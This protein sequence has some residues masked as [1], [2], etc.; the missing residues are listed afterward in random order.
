M[1]NALSTF[2][3]MS[4]FFVLL[5]FITT[6][7]VHG[8]PVKP[9]RGYYGIGAQLR[10]PYGQFDDYDELAETDPDFHLL[11]HPLKRSRYFTQRLGK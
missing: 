4:L 5:I 3:R 1:M 10:N 7:P 8:G 2:A 9:E 6:S 11:M